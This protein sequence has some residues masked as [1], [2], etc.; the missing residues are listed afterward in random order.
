MKDCDLD[1][2]LGLYL[3]PIMADYTTPNSEDGKLSLKINF[4]K[5]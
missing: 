5:L 1:N 4:E 3:G 2:F